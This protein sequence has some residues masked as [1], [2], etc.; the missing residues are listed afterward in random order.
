MA[1]KILFIQSYHI[2]YLPLFLERLGEAYEDL[3]DNLQ[4]LTTEH[5]ALNHVTMLAVSNCAR[6]GETQLPIG[7]Q[8]DLEH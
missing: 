7:S 3:V 5:M 1:R 4:K 2:K 6:E 8:L